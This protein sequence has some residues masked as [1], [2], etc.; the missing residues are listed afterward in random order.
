MEAV[1]TL[2]SP[3]VLEMLISSFVC[4]ADDPEC[5]YHAVQPMEQHVMLNSNKT[6]VA[7]EFN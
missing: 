5:L 3:V 7:D 2:A 6:S 4:Y 1:G